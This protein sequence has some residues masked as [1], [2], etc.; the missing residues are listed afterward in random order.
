MQSGADLEA[1]VGALAR[2]ASSAVLDES[3][4]IG[5]SIPIPSLSMGINEFVI[6]AGLIRFKVQSI[7]LDLLL[8]C[9]VIADIHRNFHCLIQILAS[10]RG[11]PHDELLLLGEY[12]DHRQYPLDVLMLLF[13]FSKA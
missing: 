1:T 8:P 4:H 7:V 6:G 10:I 2:V 3:I 5:H 11:S 9:L 12:V 13:S